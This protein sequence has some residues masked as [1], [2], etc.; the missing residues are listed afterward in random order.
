L[1][2]QSILDE[3]VRRRRAISD[4]TATQFNDKGLPL[5]SSKPGSS[6]IL[7]IDFDGHSTDATNIWGVM[8]ALPFS[9]DD[10]F[11]TFSSSEQAIILDIWRRV[12]EDF[13]P[14]DYDVTT[15]H[16]QYQHA[17]NRS[18]DALRSNQRLAPLQHVPW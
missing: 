4:L 3:P 6:N 17:N 2:E 14:F 11:S 18:H 16:T 1:P 15:V 13:A 5:L 8:E 7:F 10:D 9:T 12:T